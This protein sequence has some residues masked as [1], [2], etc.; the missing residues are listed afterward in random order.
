MTTVN[1]F[2][3]AWG[4][5]ALTITWQLAVLAVLVWACEWALRLRQA[6]V[7]YT[8]WWCVLAVPLVLAPA[9]LAL[10]RRDA[11]VAVP[12]PQPVVRAVALTQSLDPLP[13]LRQVPPRPAAAPSVEPGPTAAPQPAFSRGL[14]LSWPA[15][16]MVAW[17]L[18]CGAVAARMALGHRSLLR[19]IAASGAVTD[20]DALEAVE[21]LRHEAGVR[22]EVAL[23][24]TQ[25]VGAPL[26]YGIRRPVILM[27]EEWLESLSREDLRVM[28]AHEMAHVKRSD[29]LGNLLQRIA[30]LPLFFHPATWLAG[31]RIALAREELCDA[32]ALRPGIDPKSY[33]LSLLAAAEKTHA[34]F[35][36]ASVGVAEGKFTLLR[37][38]EAIM[39]TG[40]MKRTNRY[41]AAGLALVLLA[42]AAALGMAEG[43]VFGLHGRTPRRAGGVRRRF[44]SQ[45]SHP[46]DFCGARPAECGG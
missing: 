42:A 31:R 46:A 38:V 39:R 36:L 24:A 34:R 4:P 20:A 6:R 28:L 27:P 19:M 41:L 12:A 33:A 30:E 1:G 35:A 25:A 45:Q 8:L 18:G 17:L 43:A 13:A 23:R 10:E 9:R 22:R 26:L 7:R 29:F 44:R 3:D 11:L 2:A 14:E 5:L 16:L 15:L 32:A 37:R 21:S 40:G